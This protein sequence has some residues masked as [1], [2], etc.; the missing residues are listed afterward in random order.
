MPDEPELE[1]GEVR[2]KPSPQLWR[3]LGWL[4]RNTL[5]GKNEH[6]VAKQVLTA[7]LTEMKTIKTRKRPNAVGRREVAS[8][9]TGDAAT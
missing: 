3:Y 1:A 6:E 7:K 9:K 2:F 4:S 8:A 5:L